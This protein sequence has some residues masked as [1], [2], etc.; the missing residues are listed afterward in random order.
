MD[1]VKN[2]LKQTRL[3]SSKIIFELLE[4]QTFANEDIVSEMITEL[5]S[6][7]FKIAIDDFGT[8]HSNF[9]HIATIE[10]DYI[11]IDGMFIKNL[12][13]DALSEK[14]VKTLVSFANS[15]GALTIAEFVHN[16]AVFE[17]VKS[18]G[19]DYAQGYYKSPPISPRELKEMMH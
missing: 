3:D 14:M 18:L 15:I 8:G 13:S 7:G 1:F 10:V 9:A 5:K 4:T 6:L 2:K 19:V 12:E 16:E 17:F 11:K